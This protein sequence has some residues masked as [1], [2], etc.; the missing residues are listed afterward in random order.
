MIT[1]NLIIDVLIGEAALLSG[2]ILTFVVHGCWLWWYRRW[3][4]PRLA[5]ARSVLA[6]GL[7]S[8][9]LPT[10][11]LHLP[12]RLSA[13]LQV[14]LL[15]DLAR[16]LHGFGRHRLSEMAYELGLIERAERRCLSRFWWRRLEGARHLTV[17]E[18][19]EKVVPTLLRDRHPSVRAQAAEWAADH[20]TP[21]VIAGLLFLL[22]DDD[23]SSRFTV[24]DSLMRM[25]SVVVDPLVEYIWTHSGHA[26]EAALRVA[27]GLADPRFL[28]VALARC[29]DESPKVR[30][31]AANVVGAIGGIN[32]TEV[33]MGILADAD[34]RVRASAARALG[35]LTHWPAAPA[36]IP[37]LRD[38]YWIVRREAGLA[39]R[40]L[41]APG[42]LFLRRTLSDQDHFA[43]DMARQV[44]DLP[45]TTE[46]S[47]AV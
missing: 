6:F 39:L 8:P 12:Q 38:R 40:A 21:E 10:L 43:A 47:M 16:N 13:G 42:T 15:V 9:S 45:D 31:L 5:K 24:Q 33:L 11:Q 25:G 29:S 20:P 1:A 41:G 2:C 30:A 46:W 23:V 14:R 17:T 36:L 19:G 32:G 26:I 18:A 34:P 3:S 28:A 37:L 35:K 22:N 27:A 44:L 4:R 7:G